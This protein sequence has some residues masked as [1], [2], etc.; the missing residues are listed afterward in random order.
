MKQG[1]TGKLNMAEPKSVEVRV[2]FLPPLSSTV[3]RDSVGLM[4][5]GEPTVQTV[6]DALVQ[7]FDNSKFRDHL[8]DTKGRMIP[9]WCVLVNG[10]TVALNDPEGATTAVED[11]DEVTFLLNLAGG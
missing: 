7:R 1:E 10:R 3:G 11:G 9:V 4:L 5:E 2:R 8:Y 6:I